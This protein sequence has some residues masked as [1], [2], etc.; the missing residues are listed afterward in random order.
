MHVILH[1][2]NVF[3]HLKIWDKLLRLYKSVQLHCYH[4]TH[5]DL[6]YLIFWPQIL[7]SYG[8]L[9]CFPLYVFEKGNI[10][11]LKEKFLL[12]VPARITHDSQNQASE[13]SEN[14]WC[15]KR[16]KAS[17]FKL[18][19][20]YISIFIFGKFCLELNYKGTYSF[21][22]VY[23]NLYIYFSLLLCHLNFL[24]VCTEREKHNCSMR[25]C[26]AD[27]LM[28]NFTRYKERTCES[29]VKTW[30]AEDQSQR[31]VLKSSKGK[32]KHKET[33][34]GFSV[35][36][37]ILICFHPIKR[38]NISESH[39]NSI[40]ICR[41]PN[42]DWIQ[43]NLV[44]IAHKGFVPRKGKLILGTAVKDKCGHS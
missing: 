31:S 30:T 4:K 28:P 11:S 5:V 3:Y 36:V 32:R 37:Y 15:H 10:V 12:S 14:S 18:Q 16:Q 44:W 21:M 27:Q 42:A 40:C 13:S 38:K 20:T 24:Y 19:T 39:A 25:A 43:R 34:Q 8:N 33:L 1:S 22:Y 41:L 23:L 35:L 6:H 7:C 9:Q 2:A 17:Q 26:L 29:G